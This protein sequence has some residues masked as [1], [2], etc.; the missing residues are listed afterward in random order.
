MKISK[1][2]RE[3][4][5]DNE[6]ETTVYLLLL[7]SLIIQQLVY[8]QDNKYL[9]VAMKNTAHAYFGRPYSVFRWENSSFSN[10]C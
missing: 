6:T 2:L 4:N 7:L 3:K 9:K 8:I 1:I 5:K 10:R